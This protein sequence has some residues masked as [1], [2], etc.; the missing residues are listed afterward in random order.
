MTSMTETK[1]VGPGTVLE[2]PG[3]RSQLYYR[4]IPRELPEAIASINACGWAQFLIHIDEDFSD[5]RGLF[6][7]ECVFLLPPEIYQHV[8]H[9]SDAEGLV[10]DPVQELQRRIQALKQE[11]A[12]LKTELMEVRRAES[13]DN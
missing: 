11:N 4:V 12:K 8:L 13:K 6:A 7:C 10:W 2:H 5:E 3:P 1:P 9:E